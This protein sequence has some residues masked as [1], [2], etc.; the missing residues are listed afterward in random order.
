[1]TA[2][3][4]VAGTVTRTFDCQ[5]NKGVQPVAITDLYFLDGDRIMTASGGG[6]P[7][8]EECRFPPG[9]PM[10]FDQLLHAF[11]PL[12]ASR[13]AT[14]KVDGDTLTIASQRGLINA[15]TFTRASD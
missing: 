10:A 11:D 2:T 15:L 6:G 7:A 9:D 5:R 3:F 12:P 1:M 4:D 8:G 13:E 14:W